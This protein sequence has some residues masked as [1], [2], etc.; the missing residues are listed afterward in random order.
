M[1]LRSTLWAAGAVGL[2]LAWAVSQALAHTN[3]LGL[4][5][6]EWAM[7]N[8]DRTLSGGYPDSLGLFAFPRRQLPTVN[9]TDGRRCVEASFI[10]LDIDSTF[11]FDI[12]ETVELHRKLE[13]TARADTAGQVSVQAQRLMTLVAAVPASAEIM[14]MNGTWEMIPEKC[15]GSWPDQ[16]TLI[17]ENSEG[18]QRYTASYT[19][20]GESGTYEWE[21][22]YD[23]RDHPTSGTLA[24]TA[25]I[26]RLGQKSEFVV[27]K[28]DGRIT[29]TYTRVLVDEDQTLISVGCSA[30]GE[31]RW[32]RVFEKQ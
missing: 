3:P 23:G 20:V 28:R 7:P 32:V 18:I 10:A 29:Q 24:D 21:I 27:N 2:P 5:E 13:N 31:V 19:S 25:S 11:A 30:I 15:L 1:R 16:E 12:D 8:I 14:E 26:R 6:I 17:F 4:V 9:E 22:Q